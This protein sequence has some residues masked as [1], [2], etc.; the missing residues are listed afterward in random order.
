MHLIPTYNDVVA[1]NNV[2]NTLANFGVKSNI[3]IA[4]T[5]NIDIIT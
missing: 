4:N 1:K 3:H 5:S 2:N